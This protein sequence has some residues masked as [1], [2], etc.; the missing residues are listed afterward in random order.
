MHETRGAGSRGQCDQGSETLLKTALGKR[1]ERL[2]N[3]AF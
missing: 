3:F 1:A 2:F